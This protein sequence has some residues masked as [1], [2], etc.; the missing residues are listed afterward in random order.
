M[1]KVEKHKG[2]RASLTLLN[3]REDKLPRHLRHQDVGPW[4][5]SWNTRAV[6]HPWPFWTFGNTSPQKIFDIKT[7]EMKTVE[8]H[9]GCRASRTL[10]NVWKADVLLRPVLQ[11][12]PA[13]AS[14]F[15]GSP[16]YEAPKN[17]HQNANSYKGFKEER[18]PEVLLFGGLFSRMPQALLWRCWRWKRLRN[19]RAVE[20]PWPFWT[21]GK[22]SS[23][24]IFDFKMWETQG[25]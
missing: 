8:K 7:L 21:F 25:L 6:E 1:E 3:V 19:T 13:S 18:S 12:S 9:K 15:G 23:Q 17:E 5:R 10:L 16:P 4:K 14:S 24:D 20:H 2:C 11:A 22:T